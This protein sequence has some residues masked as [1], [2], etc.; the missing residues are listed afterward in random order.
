M[1]P[2]QIEAWLYKRC[3]AS[4]KYQLLKYYSNMIYDK[5]LFAIV[6]GINKYSNTEII[7]GLKGRVR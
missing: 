3:F 5:K 6:V 7:G 4:E 2:N 1:F